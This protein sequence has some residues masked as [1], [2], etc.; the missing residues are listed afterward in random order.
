MHVPRESAEDS[1]DPLNTD[2]M[3]QTFVSWDGFVIYEVALTSRTGSFREGSQK[4][5]L[6]PGHPWALKRSWLKL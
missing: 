1:R 5:E 3:G 2:P 6:G 4:T